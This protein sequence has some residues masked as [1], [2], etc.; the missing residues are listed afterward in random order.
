MSLS[1][2]VTVYQA[3]VTKIDTRHARG[4]QTAA[5]NSRQRHYLVSRAFG[6]CSAD[7]V[8]RASKMPWLRTLGWLA[9]GLGRLIKAA[10]ML[11]MLGLVATVMLWWSR[12]CFTELLA[13]IPGV[14]GFNFEV[15][16]TDCW[17]NPETGVFVSRPRQSGKTLLFLYDSLEVP[18]ITSIDDNSNCSGRRR[19]H[20]LPQRQMAGSDHQV[21][22]PQHSTARESS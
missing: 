13:N 6:Y 22:H 7:E 3:D 16:M 8:L 11:G 14:S 20:L 15:S 1:I 4:G 12:G 10:A 17:H 2:L 9:R 21:R 5:S 18:A 19:C